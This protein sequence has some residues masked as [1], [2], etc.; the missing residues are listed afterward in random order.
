[1]V[2]NTG[3]FEVNQPEG[4]GLRVRLKAS[5]AKSPTRTAGRRHRGASVKTT[6]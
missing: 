3:A 1:M 2:R 4:S 6:D 5:E